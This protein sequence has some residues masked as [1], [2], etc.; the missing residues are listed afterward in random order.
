[1]PSLG[2]CATS[3]S[4]DWGTP[5]RIVNAVREFFGGGIALDPCANNHS[6]VHAQHSYMLPRTDGLTASWNYP[7]IFVNPPYGR[8]TSRGTSIFDWLRKCVVANE[9]FGSEV[10]ALVPVATNTQHW[11]MFV[12][13]FAAAI[14]FLADTRLKFLEAGKESK[15]G[16]PM[17]CALVYWGNR[18]HDFHDAFAEN[19]GTTVLLRKESEK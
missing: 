10:I 18:P 16:A 11:K 9:Q 4:K 2:R 19:F 13:P 15:K 7:T 1:M 14:C 5:P 8:D 6:I 3:N 12:F 17:A